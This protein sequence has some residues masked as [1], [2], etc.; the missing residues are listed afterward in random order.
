MSILNSIT[1]QTGAKS[2]LPATENFALQVSKYD[3]TGSEP[4]I[5]GTRLDTGEEVTV[6]LRAYRGAKQLKAPRAE[7]KDF[8]AAEG[9]IST[10]MQQ[11][12][13]EEL[14][15]Q[16]MKGQVAKTEP[17]G[18]IIV[19]RG[20]VDSKTGMTSAGWLQSAAKYPGHAKV[21]PN[22]MLRV[23]PVTHRENGSTATAT[24]INPDASTLVK[25]GVELAAAL[26]SA[27]RGENSPTKGFYGAL[28]RLSD[29]STNKA[30]ELSL[31][32]LK[33]KETGEY[34]DMAPD[35]AVAR[36]LASPNGK[37]IAEFAVKDFLKV[38]VIPM[39]RLVL[40]SQT[41]ASYE[42]SEGKLDA[43]NK[44][45]RLVRDDADETAFAASYMV[46][47]RV[48]EVEVFTQAQPLSNKPSLYHARD[49][50]TPHFDGKSVTLEIKPAPLEGE[51]EPM[52]SVGD[53]MDFDVNEVVAAATAPAAQPSRMRM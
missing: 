17:G 35:A 23:D 8:V 16:V 18:T 45:Y 52:E 1:E 31:P 9:E 22:V 10:L 24:A 4:T 15:R 19:Q 21:L 41:K 33:N 42:K 40:G 37:Q 36:F 6:T 44:A 32:R 27:F 43:V 30:V 20:F 29:G 53:D 7:I 39:A 49:I 3:L 11:L 28:I 46:I 48:G 14:R 50:A 12:P 26:M 38:E 13:T 51:P 34:S 5:V 2:A 25:S 47:H